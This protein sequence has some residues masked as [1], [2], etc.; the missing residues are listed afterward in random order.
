MATLGRLVFAVVDL[1][2]LELSVF[3]ARVLHTTLAVWVLLLLLLLLLVGSVLRAL[4]GRVLGLRRLLALGLLRGLGLCLWVL[5][6]G[7]VGV[8]LG[9]HGWRTCTS[10]LR[11]CERVAYLNNSFLP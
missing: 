7:V 2:H 10:D 8:F 9:V 1:R 11:W 5:G 4:E 3:G 6:H